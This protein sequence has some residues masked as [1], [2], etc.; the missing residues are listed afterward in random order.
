MVKSPP[1]NCTHDF[2]MQPNLQLAATFWKEQR[3]IITRI[4]YKHTSKRDKSV[5]IFIVL[6]LEAS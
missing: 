4:T 5:L 6:I 3:K 2:T 1:W